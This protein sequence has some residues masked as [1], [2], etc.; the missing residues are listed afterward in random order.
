MSSILKFKGHYFVLAFI[1]F[2]IEVLIALFAH[3]RFI[4]PYLGDFLVV[5]LI[6]CFLRSFIDISVV[7]LALS[8]L[9]FSFMVET[10]QYFNILGRLGLQD[11]R[12]AKTLMGSSFEWTDLVAYTLGI[13]FVLYVEK[14]ILNKFFKRS[15]RE[16]SQHNKE[17]A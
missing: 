5:I 7:K 6:Y 10:L 8:A 3:D 11:S 1:I 14:M 2:C 12:L 16:P 17:N 9:L 15:M 4:R 13:A